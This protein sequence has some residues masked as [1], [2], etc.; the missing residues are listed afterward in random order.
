[1]ARARRGIDYDTEIMKVEAQITRW[2]KTI[3]ELEEKRRAFKRKTRSGN[4]HALRR[5]AAFWQNRRRCPVLAL[6]YAN[7]TCRLTSI[8]FLVNL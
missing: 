3:I 2:K 7:R 4:Q 5:H 6:S 1:M 8:R